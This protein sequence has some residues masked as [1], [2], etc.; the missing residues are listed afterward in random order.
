MIGGFGSIGWLKPIFHGARK[1]E[2]YQTF[3]WRRCAAAED[4]FALFDPFDLK[5]LPSANA[6]LLPNFNRQDNLA[7]AG[8]RGRHRR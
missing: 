5:F 8:N 6:I 7:F 1:K 2:L 4:V 3:I